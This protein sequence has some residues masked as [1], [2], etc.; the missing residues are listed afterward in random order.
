MSLRG[1]PSTRDHRSADKAAQDLAEFRRIR[2]RQPFESHHPA[3]DDRRSRL[4]H[5]CQCPRLVRHPARPHRLSH[6]EHLPPNGK[7]IEHRNT[8]TC[9]SLP[10][11]THCRRSASGAV[12]KAPSLT[13][14]NATCRRCCQRKTAGAARPPA[15]QWPRRN[16]LSPAPA[17]SSPVP[18]PPAIP[19][20][21]HRRPLVD[22]RHQ[23]V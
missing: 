3:T 19:V 18:D 22:G 8:Q 23:R 20:P 14:E 10:Q 7:Q 4:L 1:R 9:A 21:Q 11:T 15:A 13:P 16:A 12:S 2:V 5:A 17:P 6:H